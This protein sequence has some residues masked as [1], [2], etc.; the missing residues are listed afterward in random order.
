[1]KKLLLLVFA[2]ILVYAGHAQTFYFGNDLSYVNQMED[3]GAVYKEEGVPKDVY[4]I[5]ADHGSNLVRVRLWVDPEWQHELVQPE[6]VKA[7][8]SD[9]EDVKE[10][11]ARA[12]AAGMEVM[13]GIHYSDVWADPGRQLIPSRW[14]S[15]ASDPEAL[16]QAVYDYTVDV[17]SRLDAEGLM[18]EIVKI[19]NENNSGILL[20]T[21]MNERFE[22]SGTV[23]TSWSRHAQLF[24]A[25]IRAVR[26]VGSTASIN[27]KIALHYSGLNWLK[28]WYQRLIDHG[29]TDFDMMGFSYYYAWHEGSIDALG[30]TVRDMVSSF[31]E[32]EVMVAETGYLWTTQNFDPLGNIITT[33]DPEYLPVIPE[34]QLEYM[35]DFTREVMRSGGTG[36]IFWEPAWVSTPCRTPWGQ[37]SSHD[38]VAFFDPENTNF[39][40]NGAGRWAEPQFYQD[41]ESVK[42]TFKVGM[43]EEDDSQ[44]AFI[45]GDF[46]GET[47]EIFPMADEGNGVYSYVTY[48]PPGAEGAYHFLNAND[49]E[50]R[51]TVP[52]A[53]A[54]MGDHNRGYV[55]P[56]SDVEFANQWGTCQPIGEREQKE[57]VQVTFKVDMSGQDVSQDVYVTGHFTGEVDWQLI[58]MTLEGDHIYSYT[59]TL[60]TGA[61]GAFYFLNDNDW[62]AR[63]TVPEACAVWWESDR[64]YVIPDHEVEFAFHWSSCEEID[65]RITAVFD[66]KL[67][68]G[69]QV[70]P[71]PAEEFLRIQ[72][73]Q[74]A[75]GIHF[76]L[77]SF[78]GKTIMHTTALSTDRSGKLKIDTAEL[79]AGIY[80]LRI[81]SQGRNVGNRKFV[82]Q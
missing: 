6:G 77:V 71:N 68:A 31:P 51:E 74:P 2:N 44:G 25:A 59:T 8:Y 66:Q 78:S 24:N 47:W 29:V 67:S 54:T 4:Q 14:L 63:E 9:F 76:E 3:C 49:P 36:V 39:M 7:Q 73:E 62:A 37:G 69:M 34:K 27:P 23:S 26:A 60:E 16:E 70:Y 82:K 32:Y 75:S 45:S 28:G 80:L 1:M 35:V 30:R 38:H 56:D 5:F 42:V 40:E 81:Y 64:G 53:C 17:L 15:I 61:E 10:T 58:P 65:S 41:L 22:A 19:G 18:P 43:S 55:I 48:L 11:I 72:F 33:P 12:K 50:A 21:S 52:E 79:P 57:M 46:S 20:H 13:L